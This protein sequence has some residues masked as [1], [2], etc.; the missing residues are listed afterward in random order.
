MKLSENILHYFDVKYFVL[1]YSI[2]AV[3]QCTHKVCHEFFPLTSLLR[4]SAAFPRDA[5][6]IIAVCLSK[7]NQYLRVW[8]QKLP[9]VVTL[10]SG[11]TQGSWLFFKHK[12]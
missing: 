7:N 2:H 5:T 6:E 12:V 3:P 10:L 1:E 4:N 9:L 8:S 11:Q